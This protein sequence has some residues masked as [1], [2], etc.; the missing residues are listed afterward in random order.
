[1]GT[2]FTTPEKTIRT[3]KPGDKLF[4]IR[5]GLMMS[6]RPCLD[7]SWDCPNHIARLIID[8]YNR[9]W[10]KAVANV[11]EKEYVLLGLADEQ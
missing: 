1:M 11:T 7:V 9:G 3:I 2:I 4:K 6:D 5:I 8:A 10:V